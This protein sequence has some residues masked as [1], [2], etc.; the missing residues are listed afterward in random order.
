MDKKLLLALIGL[1]G[2]IIY[3]KPKKVQA[4]EPVP[5]KK[6][7]APIIFPEQVPVSIRPSETFEVP[8]QSVSPSV[9]T[10]VI[11]EVPKVLPKPIPPPSITPGIPIL[12]T[13]P[14]VPTPVLLDE[15]APEWTMTPVTPEPVSVVTPIV[16]PEP[17]EV[18]S[19]ELIDAHESLE[20][21]PSLSSLYVMKLGFL[22]I[23][24]L[25]VYA[26]GRT[27]PYTR[28]DLRKV[29]Q[30]TVPDL[31]TIVVPEIQ[32][33][34]TYLQTLLETQKV[35]F[36]EVVKQRRDRFARFRP[37]FTI[38]EA[39]SK[40]YFNTFL[41]QAYINA[42]SMVSSNYDFD[43]AVNNFNTVLRQTKSMTTSIAQTFKPA[44]FEAQTLLITFK[45]RGSHITM[46]YL[47]PEE[48]YAYVLKVLVSGDEYARLSTKNKQSYVSLDEFIPKKEVAVAGD[49]IILPVGTGATEFYKFKLRPNEREPVERRIGGKL[50]RFFISPSVYMYY[51]FPDKS[52]L[53]FNLFE[54][55]EEYEYKKKPE[56]APILIKHYVDK[57]LSKF[58][59]S[60][61]YISQLPTWN[62]RYELGRSLVNLTVAKTVYDLRQAGEDVT[63]YTQR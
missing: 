4:A 16:T 60:T 6:V 8:V 26:T 45:T 56:L 58:Q 23:N 59:N 33:A 11:V 53:A 5:K 7:F 46:K 44:S 2:L 24:P 17:I 18:I 37:K 34:I 21:I 39:V 40:N 35:Q 48:Q 28:V 41:R 32:E 3:I 25:V 62:M 27:G 61:S 50:Q 30:L 63:K 1:G 19:P 42:G 15:P 12:I 57:I 47:A 13:K 31:S 38:E 14:L 49:D 10:K 51:R 20:T 52:L 54:L 29:S 55:F 36:S 9:P 43:K 22:Q